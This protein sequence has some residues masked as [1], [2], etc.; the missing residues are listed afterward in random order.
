MYIDGKKVTKLE[1][2]DKTERPRHCKICDS[3]ST[4]KVKISFD[5][6]YTKIIDICSDCLIIDGWFFD[7]E[8]MS[9]KQY[10]LKSNRI[11]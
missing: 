6:G 3:L 8:D 1:I 11:K 7:K 9:G 4:L 5:S 10:I 2:V